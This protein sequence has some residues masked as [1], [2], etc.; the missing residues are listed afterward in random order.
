MPLGER[1]KELRMAAGLSVREAAAQIGKSAGYLS[2]LE[3]RGEIPAPELILTIAEA[4]GADA[5]E[6]LKAAKEDYLQRAEQEIDA[7][8]QSALI[9]FRKEK[10]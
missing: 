1:L 6:L 5:G 2:R 8:H 7:K 3:T 10:R 9:L 4:Y